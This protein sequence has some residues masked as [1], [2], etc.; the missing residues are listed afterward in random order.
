MKQEAGQYLDTAVFPQ[1]RSIP[2]IEK[3]GKNVLNKCFL[4]VNVIV[5]LG[6]CFSTE[7]ELCYPTFLPT[8]LDLPSDFLIKKFNF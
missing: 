3:L 4:S 1:A 6:I 7:G 2:T 8:F 5:M